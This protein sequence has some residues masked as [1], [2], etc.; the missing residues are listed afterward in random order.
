MLLFD[1]NIFLIC[2]KMYI[3]KEVLAGKIG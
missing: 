2:T 1:D 3:K